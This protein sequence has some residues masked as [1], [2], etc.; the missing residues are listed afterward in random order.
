MKKSENIEKLTT[1]LNKAQA[2]MGGAVK[3]EANTFFKNKYADLSSIIKVIKPSFANNGLSYSQFPITS[4]NRIGVETVIFHSSGQF[5][6]NE[7]TMN[8]PK[9]DPQSAGSVITYCRRY[10]LQAVAGVPAVDSDAEEFMQTIRETKPEPKETKKRIGKHG[11]E[12]K[13]DMIPDNATLRK[14]GLSGRTLEELSLD[15]LDTLAGIATKPYWQEAIKAQ[16]S[17][18][19]GA[20]AQT[21]ELEWDNGTSG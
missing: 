12:S 3:G 16:K 17:I 2:E 7:F 11:E 4:E 19:A 15:E 13:W 10:A 5:V 6:S 8:V 1:A 20:I 21:A 18:E 9:A 14:K